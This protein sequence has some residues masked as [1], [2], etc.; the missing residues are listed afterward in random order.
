MSQSEDLPR[1]QRFEVMNWSYLDFDGGEVAISWG[2]FFTDCKPW[3]LPWDEN[4][5]EKPTICW[6]ICFF[7]LTFSKHPTSKSKIFVA[8]TKWMTS[9]G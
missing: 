2:T 9:L 4:Q 6:R 8:L 1:Q 5:H 3:G 7:F